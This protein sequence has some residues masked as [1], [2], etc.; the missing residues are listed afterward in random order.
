MSMPCAT[1][2]ETICKQRVRDQGIQTGIHYPIPVHLQ[3]A[4]SDLGYK[5]YDFPHSER[6][7]NEV[8]S[9]PMFPELSADQMNQ[10]VT[11]LKKI[12]C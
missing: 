7:A 6:A 2:G 4:Y 1:R 3:N 11:A 8:L 9:L 12:E 5:L 10:I